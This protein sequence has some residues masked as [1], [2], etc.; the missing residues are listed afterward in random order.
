MHSVKEINILFVIILSLFLFKYNPRTDLLLYSTFFPKTM[1]YLSTMF[2]AFK[3]AIITSIW[4][5]INLGS[6]YPEYFIKQTEMESAF[7]ITNK[8][9]LLSAILPSLAKLHP[10]QNQFFSYTIL[11]PALLTVSP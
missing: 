1:Y 3:T 4:E 10:A 6:I 8:A 9:N 7:I 5:K 2:T 11:V